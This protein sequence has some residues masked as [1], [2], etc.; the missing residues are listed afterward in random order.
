MQLHLALD[1]AFLL[2]CVNVN[3]QF[4]PRKLQQNNMLNELEFQDERPRIIHVFLHLKKMGWE[5]AAF[6][7]ILKEIICPK[8]VRRHVS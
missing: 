1:H 8:Y 4:W 3:C 2:I 5:A 7:H 6:L